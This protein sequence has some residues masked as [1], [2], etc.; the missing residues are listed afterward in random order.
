MSPARNVV[1]YEGRTPEDSRVA[2][3]PF[4]PGPDPSRHRSEERRRPMESPEVYLVP[5]PH[6][7]LR[8]SKP[9]K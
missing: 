1:Y 9:L 6:I 8:V 7:V 3:H 2:P 4:P 5:R